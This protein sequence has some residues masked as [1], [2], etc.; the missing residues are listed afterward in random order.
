[1]KKN[2]KRYLLVVLALVL[3]FA[4]G[5][6]TSDYLLKATDGEENVVEEE[7]TIASK[8]RIVSIST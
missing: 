4:A 6:F 5:K 1:M 7:I 3:V 2:I 8:L